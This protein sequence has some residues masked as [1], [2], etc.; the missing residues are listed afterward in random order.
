MKPI[1]KYF[2]DKNY[3]IHPETLS[4]HRGDDDCTEWLCVLPVIDLKY[5]NLQEDIDPVCVS[6]FPFLLLCQR[7]SLYLLSRF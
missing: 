6:V 2:Y 4:R 5:L 1:E 3:E 7:R